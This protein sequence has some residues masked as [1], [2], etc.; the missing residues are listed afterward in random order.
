M[1]LVRRA[2]AAL[3][4]VIA[5]PACV[6]QNDV[7]QTATPSIHFAVETDSVLSGMRIGA[8]RTIASSVKISEPHFVGFE[9]GRAVVT[10][11]HHQHEASAVVLDDSLMPV[12]EESRTYPPRPKSE[13]AAYLAQSRATVP[14]RDGRAFT[15]W[16]DDATGHVMAGVDN[17]LPVVLYGGDVVGCPHAATTDGQHVI[18]TFA[19][20]TEHGFDLMAA[21]VEA[22]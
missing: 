5:A 21:Q 16:T 14:L 2:V 7:K 8:L 9:D 15:V 19:A 18:V 12:S 13:P 10:Y 3:V 11:A 20:T 22:R 4:V 17:L 1:S 6:E